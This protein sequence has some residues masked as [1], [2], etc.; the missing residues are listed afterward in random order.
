MVEAYND[1]ERDYLELASSLNIP[2]GT[3]WSMIRRYQQDGEVIVGRSGGRRPRLVDEEMRRT[4]VSIVENNTSFTL[5]QI[6]AKLR[7][8]LPT[9]SH[10]S[11][12]TLH[13]ALSAQLITI[14]KL[15]TV[16]QERHRDDVAQGRKA[17]AEWLI[18]NVEEKST[19]TRA[20]STFRHCVHEAGLLEESEQYESLAKGQAR[21]L[22]S[23]LLSP[24]YGVS[25]ITA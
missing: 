11:I 19:S 24:T 1:P 18:S 2:R 10:V 5:H 23:L 12:A 22:H 13:R 3:A 4:I 21:M 7:H 14:K 20:V 8:R 15:E 9:K 16:L 25:S 6:N 17:Q